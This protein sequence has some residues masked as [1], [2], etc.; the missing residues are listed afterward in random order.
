MS[1]FARA[2]PSGIFFIAAV[3]A[4]HATG[5]SV[6]AQDAGKIGI[7]LAAGDVAECE[8]TQHQAT[9]KLI[10]KEIKAAENL[11]IPV[12]VLALGDLAYPSGR[13]EDFDCFDKSWGKLPVNKML[14]VPG[15]HEYE[16]ES[17]PHFFKYFEEREQKI[18]FQNGP[19]AGYY[20]LNFPIPADFPPGK[21]INA[22]PWHLIALNSG[23]DKGPGV[24]GDQLKWLKD[25]LKSNAEQ[26]CVLAFAHFFLF[27]SGRHGHEP[28]DYRVNK[29]LN[30]K[31]MKEPRM[32]EAFRTLHA[33]GA[34]LFISGHD[35]QYEVFKRQDADGHE[36]PSSGLR[37]FIVGTGGASLYREKYDHPSPNS[38]RPPAY[39]RGILKLE[40][41]Q[42][43]YRWQF[44][45]IEKEAKAVPAAFTAPREESCNTRVSG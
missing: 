15:N 33:S 43:R 18:V 45:P 2:I 24:A 37:S 22:K 3:F 41:L 42:D 6:H 20:S 4:V 39:A 21:V 26:R 12:R 27:S 14:P 25:D 11:G 17:P 31:V 13:K 19:N 38:E 7:L 9:A 16:D 40:L 8:S 23:G 1:G 34:S 36:Q 30:K 5:S 44:V 10:A 28:P 32:E 29:K 35:H